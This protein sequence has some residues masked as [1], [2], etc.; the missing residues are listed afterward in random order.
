MNLR[1]SFEK[2]FMYWINYKN[3]IQNFVVYNCLNDNIHFL[4]SYTIKTINN[5]KKTLPY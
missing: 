3:I 5:L 4:T 2:P 1:I